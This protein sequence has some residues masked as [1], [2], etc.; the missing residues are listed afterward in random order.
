MP[1]KVSLDNRVELF[2]NNTNIA[3]P[4][5]KDTNKFTQNILKRIV[6]R[7]RVEEKFKSVSMNQLGIKPSQSHAQLKQTVEQ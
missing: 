5:R 7:E 2:Q 6:G 4:M 1:E 3:I